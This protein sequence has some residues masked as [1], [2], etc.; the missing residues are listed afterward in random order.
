M[1]KLMNIYI[2]IYISFSYIFPKQRNVEGS[3]ISLIRNE[4]CA[5]GSPGPSGARGP[6]VDR[7]S[8]ARPAD[9]LLLFLYSIFR[10]GPHFT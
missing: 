3:S 5:S 2:Y 1:N 8:R 4:Y 9:R 10:P 6:P 7:P